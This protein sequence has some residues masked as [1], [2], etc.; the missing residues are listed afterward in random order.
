[1][2]LKFLCLR[3]QSAEAVRQSWLVKSADLEAG[4]PS[5]A[6]MTGLLSRNMLLSGGGVELAPDQRR[7]V[8]PPGRRPRLQ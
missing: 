8:Q 1:M 7:V 6:T 5:L 4:M 2:A 3:W